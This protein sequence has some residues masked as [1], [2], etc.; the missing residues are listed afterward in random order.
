MLRVILWRIKYENA[1]GHYSDAEQ[2]AL[3]ELLKRTPRNGSHKFKLTYD[4]YNVIWNAF[5]AYDHAT[6]G[7]EGDF[8]PTSHEAWQ[9]WNEWN[10]QM[11]YKLPK[12]YAR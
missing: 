7:V 12:D 1:Q 3:A 8:T 10:N 4:S 11:P 6:R 5:E 9:V 2:E